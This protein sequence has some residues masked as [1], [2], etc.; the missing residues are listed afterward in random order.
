[1]VPDAGAVFAARV[2]V[3]LLGVFA[4]AVF[5]V[6]VAVGCAGDVFAGRVVNVAAD[7][8]VEVGGLAGGCEAVG[9][10]E[11]FARCGDGLGGGLEGLQAAR[12]VGCDA[13][14]AGE[15]WADV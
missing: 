3:V 10:G 13:E 7:F 9:C 12:G 4:Q 15:G 2:A 8:E 14:M 11:G 5:E 6:A 1:M